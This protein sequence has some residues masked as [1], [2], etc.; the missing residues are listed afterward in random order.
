MTHRVLVTPA[1]S[2]LIAQLKSRFGS[3]MFHQSGGCCDGSSP[4]C[5]E[6]GDFILG[7]SDVKLGN[8]DGCEFWMS[9]DQFEYWQHTQLTLDIVQGRGSSFSIEIPTG[10]RFMIRS[11]I[12]TDDEM[13]DLEPVG[14]IED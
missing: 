9:K 4:M 14:F 2:G 13:N 7:G 8:V 1:A 5:F 10:F 12:F 11:R 3:L 6:K